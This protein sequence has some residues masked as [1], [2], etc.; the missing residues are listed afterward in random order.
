MANH[1]HYH[2]HHQHAHQH[3]L[4]H[5]DELRGQIKPSYM[6]MPSN[7]CP[8]IRPSGPSCIS[9][10]VASSS[11]W[12]QEQLSPTLKQSLCPSQGPHFINHPISVA[13]SLSLYLSIK[14]LTSKKQRKHQ[15]IYLL[16]LFHTHNLFS[17]SS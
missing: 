3:P 5:Q 11:F 2:T 8:Q 4:S 10:F 16:I 1:L 13:A 7:F 15:C 9:T 14:Y 6:G 12:P 17:P